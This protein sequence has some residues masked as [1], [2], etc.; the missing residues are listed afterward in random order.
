MESCC[1]NMDKARNA[2]IICILPTEREPR[3]IVEGLDEDMEIR[4]CPFCG[5]ELT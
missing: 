1:S 4:F 5:E 2:E 3:W